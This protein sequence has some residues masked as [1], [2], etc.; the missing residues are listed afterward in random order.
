MFPV[1]YGSNGTAT[2]PVIK[3]KFCWNSDSGDFALVKSLRQRTLASRE[4]IQKSKL[5]GVASSGIPRSR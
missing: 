3:Y 4:E 5:V 2:R 1:V